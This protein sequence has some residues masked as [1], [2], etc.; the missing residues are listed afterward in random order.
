[1]QYRSG[2]YAVGKFSVNLTGFNKENASLFGALLNLALKDL[3]PF[4]N[5]LP[6]TI[7]SLNATSF[8]PQK[9]HEANRYIKYSSTNSGSNK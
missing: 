9:D 3:L 4:S 7:E 6:I 2:D 5:Y 1:M 8:S